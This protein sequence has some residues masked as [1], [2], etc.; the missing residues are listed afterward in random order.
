MLWDGIEEGLD[1]C[2]FAR[3][4]LNFVP[5]D[6]QTEALA[7][8]V[9]RVIFNC[10]RQSGK[11][12]IAAIKALHR[13]IFFSHQLILLLSPSLR[14]SG[15]LFRKVTEY[16]TRVKMLPEKIEDSKLFVTFANGS[17]IVSLPSKEETIR[18]FSGVNLLIEDEAAQVSDDLYRAARPM[19]AVS[20]GHLLLMSTPR[21]KRGHFY[22]EWAEGGPG[23]ERIEVKAGDCPRID[24]AFLEDEI[25]ALGPRWYRQEYECS[26]E[27][28]EDSVFDYDT[29]N[30]AMDEDVKP[31]FGLA[32]SDEVKPLF[33]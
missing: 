23:W 12:S 9:P 14:Q 25:R 27:D 18:G 15:E 5:D 17:R 8:E 1:A 3:R 6:W 28:L 4:M 26:F 10:C 19:L 13:G 33:G 31:L 16:A 32:I 20:G 11:S 29:V 7:S 24:K 21:G 30:A 2:V 22:H